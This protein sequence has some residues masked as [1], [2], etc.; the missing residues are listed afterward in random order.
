M[1]CYL[2]AH[3]MATIYSIPATR[4]VMYNHRHRFRLMAKLNLGMRRAVLLCQMPMNRR[5]DLIAEGLPVIL[6]SARGFW[7]ASQQLAEQPREAEV[8]EGFAEEEAAKILILMDI[9][10]CPPKLV[11]GRIGMMVRHFY[12]HLARII[13]AE[14][15]RWKPMHVAQLREYVDSE[16]QAHYLE[17]DMGE[18]ILPNW[19]VA[20]RE[21]ILYADIEAYEDGVP[22]W[23]RPTGVAFPIPSPVPAVLRVAEALSAVG[24][25]SRKGL[26]AVA[27]AWGQLDF[28]DNETH[29]DAQ[30]LTEQM[31]TRLVKE[32][33]P[34]EAATQRD[35]G[36]LSNSW[37]M[38]MY[39][40]EF[41]LID[42]PLE[43]L[44][45]ERDAVL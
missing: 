12:D 14:A 42:V 41:R 40:F 23:N 27:D 29:A 34:S 38:P 11:Q 19:S 35:V 15:Q 5:L 21:S 17:G 9:V 43:D 2:R 44:Q 10:R 36:I 16:R 25:F 20:R 6:D 33:L 22:H 39:H 28:R 37:Q 45:R 30:R 26:D 13:Y 1:V 32:Q 18:Y 3:P 8:L 24:A 31:L 7:Q 4:A